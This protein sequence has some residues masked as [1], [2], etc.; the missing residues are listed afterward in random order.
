MSKEMR[1]QINKVKN[2]KQFLN[3][4]VFRNENLIKKILKKLGILEYK[5]LGI[6]QHGAAIYNLDDNKV[7][8]FTTSKNEIKI[9][10]TLLNN[11]LT[12][13]PF[14]YKLS[15]ID[16]IDYYIR[17]VFFEIDEDLAEKIDEEIE[18]IKLFFYEKNMDVR[19]SNTN[20]EYY[21]DDK[22]LNFLNVLKKDLFNIGIKDDFDIEGLSLNLCQ[23]KNGN[24]IL[25]DF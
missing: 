7:Y 20:L 24:F 21:F 18:D 12:S 4:N 1:E 8:K 13:L 15:S 6:G 19:K 9:V 14:I 16:G 3:E 5:I 2:W 25:V 17:D 10:K 11:H 22:F 23:D